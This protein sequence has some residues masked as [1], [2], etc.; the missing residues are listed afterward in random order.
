MKRFTLS[1]AFAVLALAVLTLGAFAA[2]NHFRSLMEPDIIVPLPVN[3]DSEALGEATF[4]LSKDEM[5]ITYQLAVKNI[6]H[7]TQAHIHEYVGDGRNGPIMVWLFP[8]PESTA[9][10][11][12]TGPVRGKLIRSSFGPENLRNN[13]TWEQVLDMLR[14]GQAYVNVHTTEAPGGEI[15]GHI[16]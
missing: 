9:P 12:P 10:G 4:R 2:Q 5:A 16:H 15:N 3:V 7:I 13:Y 6:D 1:A 8:S 14:S 11:D